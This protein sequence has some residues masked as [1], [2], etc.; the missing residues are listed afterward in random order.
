MEEVRNQS[1]RKDSAFVC[2]STFLQ[3]TEKKTQQIDQVGL[4]IFKLTH[5]VTSLFDARCRIIE[6]LRRLY[7]RLCPHIVPRVHTHKGRDV[8]FSCSSIPMIIYG[9]GETAYSCRKP[10]SCSF[11]ADKI[12]HSNQVSSWHQGIILVL[13]D[14]SNRTSWFSLLYN[15]MPK[16]KRLTSLAFVDWPCW[17][18]LNPCWLP[19][20]GVDLI[21]WLSTLTCTEPFYLYPD[22]NLYILLSSLVH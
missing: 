16:C 7:L 20:M 11:F 10:N 21:V 17:L 15:L 14:T 18:T 13:V 5:S 4:E 19:I 9:V 3:A 1:H 22:E 12:L 6:S 8:L 2:S